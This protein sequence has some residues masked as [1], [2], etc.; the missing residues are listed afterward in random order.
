MEK[1]VFFSFDEYTRH[2]DTAISRVDEYTRHRGII[3]SCDATSIL[4]IV[5][6]VFQPRASKR[7]A[8]WLH[9]RAPRERRTLFA[10][11]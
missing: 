4:V 1:G 10:K 3:V 5:S 6:R 9:N 7:A 11:R 2:E 8:N